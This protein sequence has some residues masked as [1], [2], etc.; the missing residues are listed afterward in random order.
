MCS[1]RSETKNMRLASSRCAI[2][3]IEIFGLPA[4]VYSIDCTSSGSP[5]SQA[6][7]LGAASTLLSDMASEKRS[8]E[9]KN[10]S[11]SSTP[12]RSMP[13]FCMRAP[14]G[15]RQ[16]QSSRRARHSALE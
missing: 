13:G 2:D 7:K 4:F 16:A 14:R 9:E 11:R 12:T 8:F 5:E 10:V 6:A 1:S 3:T 15:P